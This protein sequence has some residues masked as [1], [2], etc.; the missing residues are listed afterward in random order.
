[1]RSQESYIG[2]IRY[3]HQMWPYFQQSY[4][5]VYF[6]VSIKGGCV[7]PAKMHMCISVYPSKVAVW[8]QQSYICVFRYI[9]QRWLCGTSKV[10]YVYFGISIK[11]NCVFSAKL[12]RCISVYPSKV[13]V[14]IQQNYIGVFRYI[15]LM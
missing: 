11:C 9:H 5:S 7:V 4:T 8:S 14:F 1:M 2:V 6:G 15:H 3:I 10:T 12:Y 13:D